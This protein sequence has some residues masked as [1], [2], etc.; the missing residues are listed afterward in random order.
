VFGKKSLQI[1]NKYRFISAQYGASIQDYSYLFLI[2]FFFECRKLTQTVVLPDRFGAILDIRHVVTPNHRS[3][4]TPCHSRQENTDSNSAAS[5]FDDLIAIATSTGHVLFYKTITSPKHNTSNTSSDQTDPV[6]KD[7]DGDDG[8]EIMEYSIHSVFDSS[9]LVLSI[10]FHPVIHGVFVCTLSSGEVVVLRMQQQQQ[11]LSNATGGTGERLVLVEMDRHED[12]HTGLEVWTSGFSLDGDVLYTGG[13]DGAFCRFTF[14]KNEDGDES[15]EENADEDKTK[16]SENYDTL[17]AVAQTRDRKTH[18]AGVTAILA[19][20]LP[21]SNTEVVLTGSYDCHLRVYNP[22]T[23][24]FLETEINL[25]GGVWRLETLHFEGKNGGNEDKQGRLLVLAS[26][27]HAGCRIV[28]VVE[29]EDGQVVMDI[30][31]RMEEHESMNYA[32]AALRDGEGDES[33]T[34][35]RGWTVVSTSFYDK[36]VCTWRF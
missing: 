12:V 33:K 8:V 15:G 23:R 14:G 18:T 16:K 27:M 32:S 10:M 36:R 28:E 19:V 13:D 1:L 24:K 30:V 29:Q 5:V 9:I 34:T 2:H 21:V 20:R 3:Q 7:D 22:T 4:T 6:E 26:C 25:D 31:G 17:K 35:G 11:P